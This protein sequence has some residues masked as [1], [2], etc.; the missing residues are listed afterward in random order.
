[1]AAVPAF[2]TIGKASKEVLYGGKDGTYGFDQKVTVSTTTSDGVK[3]DFTA[4][5]K[6][7]KSDL[8]LKTGY[9][10][11]RYGFTALLNTTDKVAVSA[12]ID[13]VAPG[14][15][16]TLTA[17]LPDTASGKLQLDYSNPYSCVKAVAG[18]TSSP[19]V[20]VFST[21]AY[22]N[23]VLGGHV[24]YDTSKSDITGYT[25]AL[26]YTAPDAQFALILQ[27]KLETIKLMAQHNVSKSLALAAELSRP[28]AGGDVSF[29]LG[30]TR[31]LDNGAVLK[32]KVDNTG[33]LSALLAQKLST[34][35][36]IVLSGQLDT[37]NPSKPPKV[38]V[39]IEM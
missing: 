3:L 7:E 5:K 37:N 28:V 16:A 13:K 27:D 21:T 12:S 9:T 17:T 38:G 34:G 2:D 1:M 20:D 22:K 30:A 19:K 29:A 32:T 14:L 10:F 8:M 6:G 35:E 36:K 33:V 11:G 18:L 4:A 39:S 15:K 26:G 23:F 25:A 24:G 31:K